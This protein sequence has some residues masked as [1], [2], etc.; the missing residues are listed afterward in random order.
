M[1]YQDAR[2]KETA[3][4]KTRKHPKEHGIPPVLPKPT[5]RQ[6]NYKMKPGGGGRGNRTKP[7]TPTQ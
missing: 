1:K 2:Q 5:D 3:N 4:Q 6:R 7:K